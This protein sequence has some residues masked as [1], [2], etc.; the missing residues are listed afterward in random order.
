[1]ITLIVEVDPADKQELELIKQAIRMVK[2]VKSCEN[3]DQLLVGKK[4]AEEE[5]EW[6]QFQSGK[7]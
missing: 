6:K 5:E 2:K 1:M 4:L 3:I 7:R